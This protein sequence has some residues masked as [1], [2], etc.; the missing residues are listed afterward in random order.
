MPTSRNIINLTTPSVNARC[1][2]CDEF[3]GGTLNAFSILY[4][5]SIASRV[6]L[7]S[8]NFNV[9]PTIGQIVE[10]YVLIVPKLHVR[11]F[12]DLPAGLRPELNYVLEVIR[13]ASRVGYGTCVKFEHGARTDSSGGCGVSHA[14]LH[15]VPV[16]S[17]ND[18][19]DAIKRNN[20]FEIIETFDQVFEASS[21]FPYL[22]YEDTHSKKYLFKTEH[23]P[24]QY[25]RQLLARKLGCKSWDWR[26]AKRETRLLRTIAQYSTL[27]KNQSRTHESCS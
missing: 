17:S 25:V 8:D 13:S 27:I 5:D 12:A 14:H 23:I 9:I 26:S 3:T 2:F 6:I 11:S 15:L 1:D 21:G 18:P 22:Y 7:S 16:A 24:S 20:D 10:G 19:I 4:G